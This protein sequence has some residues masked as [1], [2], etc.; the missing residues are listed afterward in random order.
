MSPQH[1]LLY[2]VLPTFG[3]IFPKPEDVADVAEHLVRLRRVPEVEHR[4]EWD[5]AGAVRAAA[6]DFR[7]SVFGLAPMGR[8]ESGT[9]S[10]TGQQATEAAGVQLTV[11]TQTDTYEQAIAAV[12]AAYGR[13]LS[14]PERG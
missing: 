8:Q 13:N 3:T 4:T 5:G 7:R 12:D 10:R 9:A 14:L 11:D 6:R 1:V 2:S